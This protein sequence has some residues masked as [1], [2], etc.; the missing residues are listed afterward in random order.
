MNRLIWAACAAALLVSAPL[1]LTQTAQAADIAL[2]LEGD[3]APGTGGGTYG[4]FA[5]P[6]ANDAGEVAFVAP[7]VGGSTSQGIFVESASESRAVALEGGAAPGGGTFAPFGFFTQIA[8]NASGNLAFSA[9]PIGA[10]N[11]FGVY[12]EIAESLNRLVLT[13]DPTP[14]TPAG[15]FTATGTPIIDDANRVTFFGAFDIGASPTTGLFQGTVGGALV[16]LLVEGDPAPGL[17]GAV[18]SEF[19]DLS[20]STN[21]SGDLLFRALI[22]AGPVSTRG[23]FLR[24]PGG[25]LAVVALEDDAAPDGGTYSFNTS[26]VESD[27]TDAGEI[28]FEATLLGGSAGSAII[29]DVSGTQ[30]AI[31]SEGD[32][33]PGTGGGTFDDFSLVLTDRG[34][35]AINASGVIA[36]RGDILGGSTTRALFKDDGGSLSFV[37][38]VGQVAPGTSGGTYSGLNFAPQ[39]LSNGEV[40]FSANVTGGTATRGIFAPEPG[41]SLGVLFGVGLLTRLTRRPGVLARPAS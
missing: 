33:A 31:A 24:S 26:G 17:A 6:S 29:R 11:G 27:L 5:E 2:L 18:F 34:G 9:I 10:S 23:L 39:I 16:A 3:L 28:T 36:F 12:V 22:T 13:G 7:V 38:G 21:G 37:T 8:L 15:V 35:P 32:V 20:L 14:T 40:I 1:A 41:L 4:F 30:S 19:A 25:T